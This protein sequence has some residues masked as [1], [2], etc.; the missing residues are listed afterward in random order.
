MFEVEKGRLRGKDLKQSGEIFN[1]KKLK[2][3][4]DNEHGELESGAVRSFS[5]KSEL[6]SL[7]GCGEQNV[8][9]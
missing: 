2:I 3:V 9:R 4:K 8:E 7:Q 1:R 6:F 5:V